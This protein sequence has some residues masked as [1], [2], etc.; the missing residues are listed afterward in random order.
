MPE[1]NSDGM[2]KLKYTPEA[3]SQLRQISKILEQ[4]AVADALIDIKLILT[5]ENRL[6]TN[7]QAN[8]HIAQGSIGLFTVS[9]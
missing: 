5:W 2:F 6:K 1:K 4:K 9:T 8:L 7:W 3:K